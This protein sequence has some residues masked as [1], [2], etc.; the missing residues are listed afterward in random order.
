M[1]GYQ[2][3]GVIC[4]RRSTTKTLKNIFEFITVS[5]TNVYQTYM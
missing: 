1:S 5:F 3:W 2:K 4:L